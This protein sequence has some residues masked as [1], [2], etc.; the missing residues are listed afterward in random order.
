SKK[1]ASKKK[2]S[3][4]KASKKKTTRKLEESPWHRMAVAAEMLREASLE[5]AAREASEGR[6]ALADFVGATRSKLSDLEEMAERGIA[7][8]TGK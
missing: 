6:Q 8:L 7:R 4:K 1:K 2:A 5:L 3:K